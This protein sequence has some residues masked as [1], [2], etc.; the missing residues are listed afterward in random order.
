VNLLEDTDSFVYLSVVHTLRT[1]L[2]MNHKHGIAILMKLFES[3]DAWAKYC[4]FTPTSKV[5][6]VRRRVLLG[7]SL[8]FG[9]RRAGEMV[10][11]Y[12]SEIIYGCLRVIRAENVKSRPVIG[13]VESWNVQKMSITEHVE[14][15]PSDAASRASSERVG[16]NAAANANANASA[17]DADADAAASQVDSILLRQS[18]IS[19]MA[20]VVATAGYGSSRYLEEVVQLAS[21]VLAVEHSSANAAIAMRR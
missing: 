5:N 6:I 11:H 2:D 7:E 4:E 9:V 18:A 16:G 21:D 3:S 19:L 17:K 14:E 1:L 13:H 12:A 8:M 20:E 15:E 10:P